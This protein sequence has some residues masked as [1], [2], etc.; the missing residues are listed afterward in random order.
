MPKKLFLASRRK[1]IKEN[2]MYDI[3]GPYPNQR[4]RRVDKIITCLTLVALVI[5]ALDLWFWR[6]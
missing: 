2:T 3:E 6:P 5:V 1:A 4:K